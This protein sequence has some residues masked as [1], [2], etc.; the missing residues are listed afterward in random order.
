[1][2]LERLDLVLYMSILLMCVRFTGHSYFV[3]D[4][5]NEKVVLLTS[6]GTFKSTGLR[7]RTQMTIFSRICT[8]ARDTN[9][10]SMVYHTRITYRKINLQLW[11]DSFGVF[12][13]CICVCMS[14]H[15]Y[16]H[17]CIC[18]SLS[19]S[20][21]LSLYA[22]VLCPISSI[23][24]TRHGKGSSMYGALRVHCRGTNAYGNEG[25]MEWCPYTVTLVGSK[26]KE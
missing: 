11:V 14:M 24:Q 15:M 9:G 18:I 19:L 23:L 21:S 5:T 17:L 20:L 8:S 12:P 26:M 13:T 10:T 3:A 6:C 1:M 25:T 16:L 7:R 2:A 22:F 4:E